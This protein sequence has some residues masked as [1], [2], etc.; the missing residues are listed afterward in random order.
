MTAPQTFNPAWWC[1]NPHWQ[2]LWPHV[3]RRRPKVPLERERLELPD[4]DFLDIAWNLDAPGPLVLV[5]HGLEGSLRSHYA[6]GL[7][8]TLHRADYRIAFMHF[9]NCSGEPNRLPRSYHSGDTADLQYVIE[10]VT[11]RTGAPPFAAVGFSLGGNVLLKWLGERGD[12]AP[13][14]TAVAVSVPFLLGEM[15]RGWSRL[16][17]THLV[18]RLRASYRR[19]FARM[20]SPLSV[21][22]NRLRTFRQFDDQVTA[23]LH[24]FAG[25]D[26]YYGRSSSR[27]FLGR[28]RV[29]T[30]I[31][32]ARDDPFMFQRTAPEPRELPP[33]VQLEMMEH[34]GHVGFVAGRWPWR[35]QWWLDGRIVAHLEAHRK[36][37]P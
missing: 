19:K 1:R 2:T 8:D 34:G 9:R 22:V 23:P 30:L 28:I 27:Q 35:P 31:V 17:Q 37:R 7:I 36:A 15:E 20:P 24:G 18:G 26:D 13:L 6:A 32:H 11:A 16:Y 4:G 21:D 25:V 3:F 33:A 5:L 14:R 29:P 12:A 10:H